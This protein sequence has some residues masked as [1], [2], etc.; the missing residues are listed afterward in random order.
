MRLYP[1]FKGDIST[2][3]RLF[4]APEELRQ[5]LFRV[6]TFKNPDYYSALMYS[7]Y[8]AT[9]LPQDICLAVDYESHVQLP[10]GFDPRSLSAKG[11][12][13]WRTAHLEDHRMSFPVMFP[14]LLITP[15]ADQKKMAD[16][17]L[18]SLSKGERPFGTNLLI[19]PT[20]AGK[21][22]AQGFL[23]GLTGERTLVLCKSN[24]IKKAWIDDMYKLYGMNEDDLG[25]IQQQTYRLGEHI[26]LASIATMSRRKHLWTEIFSNVGCLVIDEV[27]IIGAETI[28]DI[29]EHC[30]AKYIIGM[31]A[32]PTRRDG[33]NYVVNSFMG[34]PLLRILNK[35]VE[36]E[37]SFPLKDA[38]VIQTQFRFDDEEGKPIDGE[39]LDKNQLF[40]ALMS[41]AARNASLIPHV[42]A[43][44]DAGHS[45]L[46]VTPRIAHVR[47]LAFRLNKAGIPTNTLTGTS[48]TNKF[49]TDKLIASIM[50]RNCRCIVASTQAIKLGANLNPLDRLHVFGPVLNPDDLE[51][52]IG[53]IRRKHPGKKDAQLTYYHDIQCPYL[54]RKF[55]S[56]F[57]QT[58]R[59][60]RV[61]RFVNLYVA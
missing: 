27:Q 8:E 30:P 43:D 41:D 19:A 53:R 48:N 4:N 47:K 29:V 45:V 60:L 42:K 52:L 31:T 58:M 24:L 2:H 49:Y 25:E 50:N 16:R 39:D 6:L 34:K 17:F 61:P 57:F 11:Q 40:D 37:N 32:T 14:K 35:Q 15:N 7:P 3:I 9:R 12:A 18:Q 56:V 28:Q 5:D 20:S 54:H 13:I 38:K 23:A 22:I 51:Q 46:I 1:G 44:F 59:K 21:T 26:T 10:R 55:K 36:T 33:K